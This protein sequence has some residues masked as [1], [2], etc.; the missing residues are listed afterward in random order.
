MKHPHDMT[1]DELRVAA[2]AYRC[3][4]ET[5]KI[6]CN[7]VTQ[8]GRDIGDWSVLVKHRKPKRKAGEA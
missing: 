3:N 8:K 2:M 7:G 4:A 1:D 6:D 5:L